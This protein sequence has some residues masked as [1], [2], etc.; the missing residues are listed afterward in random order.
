MPCTAFRRRS[1][2]ASVPRKR[3]RYSPERSSR[4]SDKDRPARDR[5]QSPYR[6]AHATVPHTMSVILEDTH[7]VPQ[8]LAAVCSVY[9]TICNLKQQ[10]TVKQASLCLIV[11]PWPLSSCRL[12]VVFHG[13]AAV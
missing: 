3:A 2:S 7:N 4:R 9:I 5:S 8:S 1:R 13:Q 10:G 11:S 12:T 6:Q